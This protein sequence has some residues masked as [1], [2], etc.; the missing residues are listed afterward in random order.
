[1]ALMVPTWLAIFFLKRQFAQG[2][3]LVLVD[4]ERVAG[5]DPL[6]QLPNRRSGERPPGRTVVRS[7]RLLRDLRLRRLRW[8]GRG[9][10]SLVAGKKRRAPA[11]LA[12]DP[13]NVQ[14]LF[15]GL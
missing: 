11:E 2:V 10:A 15:H 1:M 13:I 3:H 6:G 4:L 12:L 14:L 5:D 8:W 9:G 7:L